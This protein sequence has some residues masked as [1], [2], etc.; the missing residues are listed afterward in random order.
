M[1]DGRRLVLVVGASGVGKDSVLG[2]ARAAFRGD[3]RVVFVRRVITRPA[4]SG[5]EDN[6]AVTSEEFAALR[7]RQ[8]FTIHWRA[9]GLAYGLPRRMDDDLA[10]GRVVVANVSRQVLDDARRR[11]PGLTVCVVMASI[12]TLR[13]RLLARGRESAAQIE[14][15]LAH[16]G[17][18]TVGPDV[19]AIANDGDLA[20]AIAAFARL[21]AQLLPVSAKPLA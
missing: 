1:P 3:P 15:R 5:G 12:D 18:P 20:D 8:A 19:V 14:A 7:D 16:V 10:L 21:I 17:A 4:G 13:T 6:V 2:G 9:H 11:Y